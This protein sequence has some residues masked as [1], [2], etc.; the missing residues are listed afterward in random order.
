MHPHTTS[1]RPSFAS[2]DDVDTIALDVQQIPQHGGAAVAYRGTPVIEDGL[3][4]GAPSSYRQDGRYAA[5]LKGKCRMT[6]GVHAS[7]HSVQPPR[8][9]A[10]SN[11]VL[12]DAKAP[13][14]SDRDH[15][16]LRF[17][18]SGDQRVG[19]VYFSVHFTVK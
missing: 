10:R 7:M 17:S 18:Q 13:H 4:V 1:L 6:D 3:A 14:L 15:S 19:W 5:S 16:A 9:G 2:N 11:R 12:A 8:K